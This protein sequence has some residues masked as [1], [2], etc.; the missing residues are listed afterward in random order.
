MQFQ[1][2]LEALRL[3]V[4]KNPQRSAAARRKAS[5][6]RPVEALEER[7]LLSV[8]SLIINGELSV[9]SD[10][11][12]SI[13]VRTNPV[14]GVSLQVIENGVQSTT[15]GR[16]MVANI[17]SINIRGGSGANTI[18]LS[19]VSSA[20][21]TSLTRVFVTGGDGDDTITGTVDFNDT[22]LAGDGNDTVT[23]GIGATSVDGGDGHDTIVAG[24]GD[25]TIEGGDG[26]DLIMAGPG[27]DSVR[28]GDGND[29]VSGEDG[30]DTIDAGDGN[31]LIN[32]NAGLD[33]ID[34]GFGDDMLMGDSDDDTIL[35]GAGKDTIG[36]GDGDDL[37]DGGAGA[38]SLFGGSGSDTYLYEA[39]I[40]SPSGSGDTI[41]GFDP[42]EDVVL[43]DQFVAGALTLSSV[44]GG[45]FTADGNGSARFTEAGGLLEIDSV[46]VMLRHARSDG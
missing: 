7:A 21:F 10:A 28:A 34:G 17:S 5:R 39:A 18:D 25:D 8:S 45:P 13:V 24:D 26:H 4:R 42:A 3:R 15:L 27:N 20:D 19:G 9:L 44:D 1:T 36:G 30:D 6:Q 29:T 38:D 41:E 12:D 37:L 35:G 23:V 14:D 16:V 32:G 22:I 31:D 11:D 46:V 40:D 2:W 43:L 33:L